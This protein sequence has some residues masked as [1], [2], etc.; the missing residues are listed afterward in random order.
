MEPEERALWSYAVHL[1]GLGLSHMK[2]ADLVL[3]FQTAGIG[4]GGR[5]I[6]FPTVCTNGGGTRVCRIFEHLT[7]WN[8]LLWFAMAELREVQPGRLAFLCRHFL[9]PLQQNCQEQ[10]ERT[11]ALIHCVLAKHHCVVSV[12]VDYDMLKGYPTLFSDALRRSTSLEKLQIDTSGLEFEEVGKLIVDVCAN[13]HL[14]ELTCS[15]I[16]LLESGNEVQARFADYLRKS[17][18]LKVLSVISM[19]C[20]SDYKVVMGPLQENS[21]ITSLTI[22]SVCI[23]LDNGAS[24]S[25]FLSADSVLTELTVVKQTWRTVCNIEPLF[26]SLKRNSMLRKLSLQRFLF[27]LADAALMS[28]TLTANTTL[29]ELDVSHTEWTFME[30]W[31]SVDSENDSAVKSAKSAWGKWWRVQPFVNALQRSVSLQRLEF[32]HIYFCDY[33][34]RRLLLAVKESDSFRQLHFLQLSCGCFCEFVDLVRE[35]GTF[36]KV[37]IRNCYSNATLFVNALNRCERLPFTGNHSFR[38]LDMKRLREICTALTLHDSITS[39]NLRTDRPFE[40]FDE[41]CATSLARYVSSTTTLRELDVTISATDKS[42]NR[43]VIAGLLANRSLERLGIYS[44]SL[45][46]SDVHV[47]TKWLQQ[48]KTLYWLSGS[49]VPEDVRVRLVSELVGCLRSSYTLTSLDISNLEKSHAHWQVIQGQLCRNASLVVRA[50]HFAT[51]STLKRCASA[52]ELVSWHP[53]VFYRLL[54]LSSMCVDEVQQ[55]LVQSKKR[56]LIDFWQLAGVVK[57]ELCCH[58][59]DDGKLQI[60]QIG[61]DAWMALR[62]FLKVGDIADA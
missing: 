45:Y 48:S 52:F 50:T 31:L 4:A 16:R 20:H 44:C 14:K 23:E 11:Y 25:G 38:S 46:D 28:D 19:S 37:A 15:E 60:D 12:V 13:C 43:I 1:E 62:K 58:E 5:T 6:P 54:H 2:A 40:S 22:D 26:K 56:L 32:G 18:T 47:F 27:S 42:V 49:F 35:T 53:L 33:E 29:Q 34:L 21:T 61:F 30:P 8:E 17:T 55:K 9:R 41:Q 7:L 36:D 10:L 59:R 24:L 3:A 57:E 51:G 39:I